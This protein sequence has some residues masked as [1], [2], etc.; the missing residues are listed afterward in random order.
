MPY[1]YSY[2]NDRF[3]CLFTGIVTWEDLF[4]ATGNLYGSEGFE[5][6]KEVL[7]MFSD[8]SKVLTTSRTHQELAYL[9]KAAMNY[10]TKLNFAF[11]AKAPD[12]KT[13]A[14]NYVKISKEIGT[15]WNFSI[16]EN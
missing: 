6:L 5:N 12:A 2:T 16:F 1:K 10:N 8:N 9:D 14:A 11:V 7:V 3:F 4:T 13:L 15:T